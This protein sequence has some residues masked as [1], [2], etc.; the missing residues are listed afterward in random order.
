MAQCGGEH[1]LHD[2]RNEKALAPDPSPDNGLRHVEEWLHVA[3]PTLGQGS[4]IPSWCSRPTTMPPG[5]TLSAACGS[6][7]RL[8]RPLS[9]QRPSTASCRQSHLSSAF[10]G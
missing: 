5:R 9:R 3:A 4:I 1:E 8:N 7:A 10:L 2:G 6:M